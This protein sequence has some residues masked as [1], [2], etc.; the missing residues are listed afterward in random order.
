MPTLDDTLLMAFADG[1]LDQAAAAEVSACIAHDPDAQDKVRQFRQSAN[2]VRAVFDQAHLR[3]GVP[4]HR[5]IPQAQPKAKLSSWPRQSLMAASLA[6]F[7]LGIGTGAGLILARPGPIFSDRLLDEVADYHL[8][9]ARES[10]HQ[11]EVPATRL[12]HIEAWLGDR[13]H[14]KLVVPDLSAQRLTFVGARLLSVDGVPVAQLLYQ[15]PGHE[16]QPMAFCI[17]PDGSPDAALRGEEHDGLREVTWSRSGYT[18][19]LAGWETQDFLTS[20]ASELAPE[21]QRTL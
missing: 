15:A 2:L 17:A 5:E 19:V 11:V 1:E 8:L 18:Y 4:G 13:L 14:R 9:Y 21:L 3:P 20:I 12:A 6:M 10:E 16:H 7:L